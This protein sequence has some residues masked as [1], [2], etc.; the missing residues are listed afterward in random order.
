MK[1]SIPH[2]VARRADGGSLAL[3]GIALSAYCPCARPSA[4]PV[5]NYG[6]ADYRQIV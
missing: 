6:E 1:N 3:P 2:L 4:M 5:L